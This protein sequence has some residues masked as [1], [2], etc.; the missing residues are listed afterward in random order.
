M[1][2]WVGAR[3]LIVGVPSPP[4][5]HCVSGLLDLVL[6]VGQVTAQGDYLLVTNQYASRQSLVLTDEGFVFL[7]S[8][9]TS[10]AV[11]KVPKVVRKLACREAVRITRTGTRR[12]ATTGTR[13]FAGG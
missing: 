2:V 11:L 1:C 9:G 13:R 8:R 6:Y 5:C 12:F 4:S 10:L 3:V 7:G